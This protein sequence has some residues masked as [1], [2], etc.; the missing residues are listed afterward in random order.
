MVSMRL[1][2]PLRNSDAWHEF[3]VWLATLYH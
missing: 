1:V 2:S 3:T